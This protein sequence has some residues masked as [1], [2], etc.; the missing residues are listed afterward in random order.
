MGAATAKYVLPEERELNKKR[1]ELAELEENL[2]QKELELATLRAE[3]IL[4]ISAYSRKYIRETVL[5]NARLL[6]SKD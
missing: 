4:P 6:K 1:A 2:S 5:K 3:M